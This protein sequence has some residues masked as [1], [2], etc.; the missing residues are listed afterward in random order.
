MVEIVADDSVLKRLDLRSNSYFL[1]VGS[2]SPNKNL[3]L[4]MRA[5]TG[6]TGSDRKFVIV[7][8]TRSAVFR[9]G[10]GSVE[11]GV[12]A[13]GRLSDAEVKALYRH[14]TALVF[15]SLY[16]GFGVPPLEGMANDCPVIA[17]RIPSVVEVCGDGALYFDPKDPDSIASSMKEI[18]NSP[19]T[20]ATLIAK[21]RERAKIYSWRNS[22]RVLSQV[23]GQ[24][25]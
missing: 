13:A 21:G 11:S 14:A 2:P 1:F 10:L 8:A 9:E 23:V 19:V 25:E 22:V 20:R 24:V 7:G 5:F 16:E 6:L 12:V 17:A 4:A 18:A 3:G 15:P